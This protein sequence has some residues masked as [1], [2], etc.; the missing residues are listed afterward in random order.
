VASAFVVEIFDPP[1]ESTSF[2]CG[3]LEPEPAQNG[4]GV[5]V[6]GDHRFATRNGTIRGVAKFND[7]GVHSYIVELE[8]DNLRVPIQT[9]FLVP[10]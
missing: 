6:V 4:V 10:R 3:I 9:V 7:S 1:I 5:N 8:P 2:P